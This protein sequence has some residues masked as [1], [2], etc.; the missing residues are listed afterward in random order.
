MSVFLRKQ[1]LQK[2][3][4]LSLVESNYDPKLKNA[5]QKVMRKIGYV[6]ELKAKYT[7]PIAH[8]EEVAKKLS[9]QSSK[10]YRDN[11]IEEAPE[12]SC[13][14]NLGHF[15][16]YRVYKLF[17]MGDEFKAISHGKRLKYDLE[18][19][20]RF[21]TL[22]QIVQPGS[23]RSEYF[24]K[25]IFIDRY[26][27]SDDQMNDAIKLIG[28]NKDNVL[29]Y[30]RSELMRFYEPNFK[31]TY[32]DGTN[33]YFEIDKENEMIKRGHEK[34]HRHDP[35]IGLGLLLDG[36]GVPLNYTTFAGN[37]SEQPELHKNIQLL[38]EQDHIEGRTVIIADKG[39]NSGDNM[40]KAHAN[41]DGYV[42][43]QKVRG[44]SAETVEWILDASDY[45]E[46]KDDGG[47]LLYKVKSQ[48]IDECP[49]KVTSKFNGGK[50]KITLTQKQVVFYS[51][52]Y[53]EKAKYE[54][55]KLIA[56][57]EDI[58][59]NPSQYLKKTVG[60]AASYIQ[61]LSFTETGEIA[62]TKKLKLDVKAIEEEAK[63]DGYYMIVTSEKD[64]SDEDVI[65][66]YRGL[67]EIEE[68]FSIM[69]G[70]LHVRPFYSKSLKGVESQILICFFSLLIL[71]LLQ[72]VYL[73]EN[74]DKAKL[75]KAKEANRRKRKNKIRLEKIGEIPM[76]QLV[77]FI[78]EYQG[79]HFEDRYLVTK[80]LNLMD[81]IERLTGVN[82]N[83]HYI[84][85]AKFKK[86]FD[87]DLQ[88]KTKMVFNHK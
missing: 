75:E 20:F 38:K 67:W 23:K 62:E 1:N 88:H 78:R 29:E 70:L 18:D 35:I 85:E 9:K 2:G 74:Y 65:K 56:K 15:L 61:E 64:A 68:S 73:K 39:L 27:F 22:S 44:A 45:K 63:L 57:A 55:A 58:I 59:R 32:F 79:Y 7:D 51:K 43:S 4:Y 3:T 26:A 87:F 13:L 47:N 52:D 54:R 53:D 80:K 16:P 82:V 83:K 19:I 40:Y 12:A 31:H 30:I 84:T 72:K 50:A 77:K 66:M 28:E 81:T 37:Q 71:R 48:I 41:G 25:D 86:Y 33:F 14:K 34:N 36:N 42:F 11:K 8:Y 6:E 49:I 46:I 60:S 5:R 17:K 21:L 10:A 76:P 69:K 24:H